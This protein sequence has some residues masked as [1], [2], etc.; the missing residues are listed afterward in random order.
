MILDVMLVQDYER[1]IS[2]SGILMFHFK[3][4][5]IT[6]TNWIK[7]VRDLKLKHLNVKTQNMNK[8]RYDITHLFL[9]GCSALNSRRN[10]EIII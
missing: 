2:N 10:F 9:P 4:T 8:Q 7:M 3:N 6:L 5:F 1:K